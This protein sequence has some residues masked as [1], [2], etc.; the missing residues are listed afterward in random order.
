M[1]RDL[2]CINSLLEQ[3]S[4]ERC[5]LIGY[6]GY[7]KIL[8]RIASDPCALPGFSLSNNVRIAFTV[9]VIPGIGAC[10]D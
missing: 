4:Q 10:S 1:K 8:F 5:E 9:N 6:L 2:S 7:L 3:S